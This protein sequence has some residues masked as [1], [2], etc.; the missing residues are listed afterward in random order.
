MMAA[1]MG[2]EKDDTDTLNRACDLGLAFQLAN[3]ARDVAEDAAAGRCY[4]PALWLKEAGIAPGGHM[5]AEHR[6]EM[7]QLITRLCDISQRYEASARV[8]AA[9]LPFRSRWAVLAAAGIYGDIARKV[10]AAGTNALNRRIHTSRREKLSWVWRAFRQ[11]Y[12]N[13]PQDIARDGLWTRKL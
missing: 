8:G 10:A 12:K 3:I 5:R 6:E 4:I 2:V 9:R 13:Q 11:A 1:V 7:T